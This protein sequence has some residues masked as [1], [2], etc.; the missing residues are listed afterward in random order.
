MRLQDKIKGQHIARASRAA[1]A[2]GWRRWSGRRQGRG[3]VAGGAP[4]RFSSSGRT[5]AAG[6]SSSEGRSHRAMTETLT[7][8]DLHVSVAGKPILHGRQ[9]ADPPRRDPRPDG[10]Q[11]LGQEHAGLCHHGPSR[12]RGDR[13]A[14]SSWTARTCWRWTARAGPGRAVPGLSAA[15][16][17]SRR[18]DGRLP[19]PRGHQRPPSRSAKRAK[20]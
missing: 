7:I 16:G 1:R 20:N 13:R 17:D 14:R 18:E 19:P 9:P 11:R 5:T 3:R 15:G 6:I 4:Q 10:P 2:L 8:S 12:L